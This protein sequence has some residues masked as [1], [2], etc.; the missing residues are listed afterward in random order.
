MTKR[1]AFVCAAAAAIALLCVTQAFASGSSEHASSTAKATVRLATWTA[2]ANL[3]VWKKAVN[4]FEQENPAVRVRLQYTPY[5]AYWDKLTVEYAGGTAP[6][7]IYT[8]PA[9]AQQLGTHGELLDLSPYIARDKVDMGLIN[10]GSEKPYIWNGKVWA[11]AFVN[12]TRYT[13]YNKTMFAQAGLPDLPKVW[14]SKSFTIDAFLSDAQK[15]TDPNTQSWGY[16]FEGNQPAS[17]FIYLFGANYWNN[18]NKPTRAVMDSPQGVSG[19][20]FVQDM[21]YRY[22]V[23][24]PPS[25][26]IGGS[27]PMFQTGKVGMVWAGYKSAAAVDQAIKAFKWG[28]STIPIGTQ[29][30]SVVSPQAFAIIS[31]SKEAKWAWDFLKFSAFGKG[32]ELLTRSTSMPANLSVSLTQ[33]SPLTPWENTLLHDAL[34]SGRPDIPSPRVK[35]QMMTIISDQMGALFANTETPEQVARKMASKIN[36]IFAKE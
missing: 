13:I 18:E 7:I 4:A 5:S 3:P 20:K 21:V 15:L 16:V 26:N 11:L 22:K 35:P 12:D 33:V 19:F 1:S 32:Q 9:N 29:R 23:A 6:D 14:N 10:P 17:R 36:A 24:P 2:A 34:K 28:I 31:K 27:D 25:E 30:I 8:P